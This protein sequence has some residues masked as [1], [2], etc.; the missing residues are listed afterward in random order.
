MEDQIE[1]D[2]PEKVIGQRQLEQSLGGFIN[3]HGGEGHERVDNTRCDVL[4][5]DGHGQVHTNDNLQGSPNEE[6]CPDSARPREVELVAQGRSKP[7]VVDICECEIVGPG[8]RFGSLTISQK[9]LSDLLALFITRIFLCSERG[10]AGSF[11][12]VLLF[13]DGGL[14]VYRLVP[15]SLVAEDGD[16]APAPVVDLDVG[17]HLEEEDG[18]Q[19]GDP[20][21]AV[22]SDKL[23]LDID[24][25]DWNDQHEEEIGHVEEHAKPDY[26]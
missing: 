11:V 18:V 2:Q 12:E 26:Y 15:H 7:E 1:K 8:G 17:P 19:D 25:N 13:D 6:G 16:G 20:S 3:V 23:R 24:H 4:L 22:H 14:P 21:G 5:N 9:L 10:R